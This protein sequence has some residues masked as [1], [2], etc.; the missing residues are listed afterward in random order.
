MN[1]G[2]STSSAF[3]KV[4]TLQTFAKRNDEKAGN[5]LFI[6]TRNFKPGL[7]VVTTEQIN[8]HYASLMTD[9]SKITIRG[10]GP[11]GSMS[12]RHEVI[13]LDDGEEYKLSFLE[14][15]DGEYCRHLKCILGSNSI[16]IPNHF[17][18]FGE[19]GQTLTQEQ[20]L[21]R[22]SDET[23]LD[24][25]KS[26]LLFL[27]GRSYDEDLKTYKDIWGLIQI[28]LVLNTN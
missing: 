18:A 8:T 13:P 20:F 25:S 6:D 26:S 7:C 21:E 27:R 2:A 4:K 14:L 15:H 16:P 23:R 11:S 9:A 19:N 5:M 24:R 22:L 3:F 10:L 1:T 28:K 12:I 17:E